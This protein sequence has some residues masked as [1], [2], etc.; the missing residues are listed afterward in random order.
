MKK[1]ELTDLQNKA[2]LEIADADDRTPEQ[3]LARV[4]STG[5]TFL[6]GEGG[7]SDNRICLKGEDGH[8]TQ[9]R[10]IDHLTKEIDNELKSNLGLLEEVS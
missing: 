2:I 7:L 9:T 5:I 3:Q 8:Y 10:T 1:L 4:I 6:Y